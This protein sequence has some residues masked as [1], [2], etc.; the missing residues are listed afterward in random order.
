[1]AKRGKRSGRRRRP[2]DTARESRRPPKR[3]RGTVADAA[4]EVDGQSSESSDG[5]SPSIDSEPALAA[6]RP[7]TVFSVAADD[8]IAATGSSDLRPRDDVE[9][10]CVFHEHDLRVERSPDEFLAIAASLGRD[11]ATPTVP[12]GDHRADSAQRHSTQNMAASSARVTPAP[13]SSSIGSLSARSVATTS[14]E[15]SNAFNSLSFAAG[16]S[17]GKADGQGAASGTHG[18]VVLALQ[19]ELPTGPRTDSNPPIDNLGPDQ[20]RS[21]EIA[22]GDVIGDP[23]ERGSR[24]TVPRVVDAV[25]GAM[26][27]MATEAEAGLSAAAAESASEEDDDYELTRLRRRGDLPVK[28]NTSTGLPSGVASLRRDQAT[29]SIRVLR[30]PGTTLAVDAST[31]IFLDELSG[32]ERRPDVQQPYMQGWADPGDTA[33]GA[34]AGSPAAHAQPSLEALSTAGGAWYKGKWYDQ[35]APSLPLR[36][37]LIDMLSL[38]PSLVRLMFEVHSP[39]RWA[40]RPSSHSSPQAMFQ[41]WRHSVM[42]IRMHRR[43]QQ[44]GRELRKQRR[45]T[46][47][48]E[49][50][51]AVRQGQSRL[52]YQLIDKLAPK[53]RFRKFQMSKGGQILTPAEE[54]EVMRKHFVQVFNDDHPVGLSQAVIDK[55]AAPFRVECHE[56]RAFLDKLPARKAGAPATAPGLPTYRSSRRAWKSIDLPVDRLPTLCVEFFFTTRKQGVKQGCPASP[57]LFEPDDPF[58]LSFEHP[59]N[60][61]LA[62]GCTAVS[63]R[64][65]QGN[66]RGTCAAIKCAY[67]S[68]L[69]TPRLPHSIKDLGPKQRCKVQ[70]EFSRVMLTGGL[71]PVVQQALPGGATHQVDRTNC[72]N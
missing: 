6:A 62:Q 5:I 3:L 28:V 31:I 41:C 58:V 63:P 53:G 10:G 42:H 57:L 48:A 50:D 23:V 20:M 52:F 55:A 44:Q 29:G 1:M 60:H 16:T 14:T 43:A 7:L 17:C 21:L 64:E 13:M 46:L 67:L 47:L 18:T 22:Q 24:D 34:G 45:L 9:D 30:P 19:G 2:R 15:T 39:G 66:R 27:A 12:R 33:G 26:A 36:L 51:Q 65:I 35:V 70:K 37:P 32:F 54:L 71:C 68:G 69:L 40:A 38:M 4:D 56:L 59:W 49:A 11:Y 25:D 61:S 8:R 72:I